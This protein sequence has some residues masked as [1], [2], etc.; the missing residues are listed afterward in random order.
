MSCSCLIGG[1]ALCG[2]CHSLRA[3]G[4][5]NADLQQQLLRLAGRVVK[6]EEAFLTQARLVEELSVQCMST[7]W[8]GEK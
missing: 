6:L 8:G 2:F 7:G 1:R 3:Q 4:E 5:R